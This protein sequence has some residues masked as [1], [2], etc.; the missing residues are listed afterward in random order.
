MV[1]C[2]ECLFIDTNWKTYKRLGETWKVCSH[3]GK[4]APVKDDIKRN[5]LRQVRYTSNF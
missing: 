3:C 2:K 1:K 5:K 4:P